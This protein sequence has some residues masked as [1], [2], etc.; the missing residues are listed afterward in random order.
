MSS[1]TLPEDSPKPPRRSWFP[2]ALVVVAVAL[3]SA[4][5]SGYIKQQPPKENPLALIPPSLTV[6]GTV[7]RASDTNQPVEFSLVNEGDMPIKVLAV[8]S[9]CS[10]MTLDTFS[11]VTLSPGE[12]KSVQIKVKIPQ[13]GEKE[14]SIRILTDYADQPIRTLAVKAVGSPP[15]KPF[16]VVSNHSISLSGNETGQPIS[17][18]FEVNTVELADAEDAWIT[19]AT[20]TSPLT[21]INVESREVQ[22]ILKDGR[23]RCVYQLRIKTSVPDKDE[24]QRLE[25]I[26]LITNREALIPPPR[27][28]VQVELTPRAQA[29]PPSVRR[30]VAKDGRNP[31]SATVIVKAVQDFQIDRIDVDQPWVE[32]MIATDSSGVSNLQKV[33]FVF[34]ITK[35]PEG[36]PVSKC[37]ATVVLRD[38]ENTTVEIPIVLTLAK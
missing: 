24:S 22:E 21:S 4:S 3:L 32:A 26:S 5:V 1:D 23:K 8:E 7:L 15:T 30:E 20:S 38:P 6:Q 28:T 27:W 17:T 13:F 16:V 2:F 12:S 18:I 34:D 37:T 35:R 10:C 9:T 19:G 31:P 11:P 29:F 36:V 33:Q 25:T 14:S